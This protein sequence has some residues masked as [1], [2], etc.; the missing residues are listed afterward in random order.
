MMR[1]I[2]TLIAVRMLTNRDAIFPVVMCECG[3]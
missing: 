3:Y 1:F 2:R